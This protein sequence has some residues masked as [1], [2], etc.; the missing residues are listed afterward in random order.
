MRKWRNIYTML[1]H[2]IF[3]KWCLLISSPGR[4]VSLGVGERC[5]QFTY[6]SVTMLHPGT[7][8]NIYSWLSFSQTLLIEGSNTG[9]YLQR[10]PDMRARR[11]YVAASHYGQIHHHSHAMFSSAFQ[12]RAEQR[13]GRLV[14][15]RPEQILTIDLS[16]AKSGNF[17]TTDDPE[18]RDPWW[19]CWCWCWPAC[20]LIYLM[21][22]LQVGQAPPTLLPSHWPWQ[23]QPAPFIW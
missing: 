7:N 17:P 23:T 20:F 19:W 12:Y 9:R 8:T 16:S 13:E 11:W 15:P 6:Y 2:F 22:R 21:M 4:V 3:T 10:W 1:Q 5:V 14:R 18:P